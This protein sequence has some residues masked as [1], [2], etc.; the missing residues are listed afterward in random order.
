MAGLDTKLKRTKFRSDQDELK[1]RAAYLYYVEGRTQE[2]VAQ[3][4]GISRI[5]ALRLLA[6]TRE[7]GTV[8]ITI[9]SPAG[10]LIK[11]QRELENHLGLSE[12]IVVP[13]SDQ[14]EE[15]VAAVVGHATGR[16]ISEHVSDGLSIG[17]GWG[18]TLQVCMRSL[19]WREVDDMTAISL[20]GG[21]THATAHNPSAVAWRFAEF[22]RTELYQITAP[23]FVPDR[24]LADALWKQ[25]DLKKLYQ[26]AR[27]VD[28]AL[29]SV[30]D[31]SKQASIFRRGILTWSDAKSLKEAGA[32][33][34]VLCHFVDSDGNVIDHPVNHRAMAINP[35]DLRNVPKVVISSGGVRKVHAIRAGIAATNARFLI[36]DVAAAEALLDLDPILRPSSKSS[37]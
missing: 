13:T 20:L 37:D 7:D 34:D 9:N 26:R 35:I 10:S 11:L 31:V 19:A 21:L 2:Q 15:S 27:E 30:G 3:H 1:L 23:V 6:A 32:V 8:Q 5:K 29:L 18:A 14:N 28:I 33:G 25:D 22:Y 24:E 17:V 12:A 36:T 4:L 16:Y